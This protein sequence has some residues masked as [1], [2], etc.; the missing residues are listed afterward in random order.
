MQVH[1]AARPLV[2]VYDDKGQATGRMVTTPA[3]MLA[4]IRPDIVSQV[5]MDMLKNGRQPYAV[6]KK[7]GQFIRR[8]VNENAHD[9][10]VIVNIL[11]F[12]VEQFATILF[13]HF[14]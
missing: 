2:S 9:S 13:I 1:A 10:F 12:F 4:P 14:Q 8:S 11:Y 6:S 5:H 3:V 7:A